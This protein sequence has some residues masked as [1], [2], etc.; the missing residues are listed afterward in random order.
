MTIA[1]T[2][3]RIAVILAI[4]SYPLVFA[5]L[6]Y[7]TDPP[8]SDP[9]ISN[10]NANINLIESGDVLIYGEHNIPYA[11]LPAEDADDT[12]IFRLIDTDNSTH[13]GA[14]LPFTQLDNGY[15]EGGFSFYFTASDNLT[16]D[17]QYIIR[18]SQNPANFDSPQHY[19]YV[20]P[21]SA[22][23]SSV[24]Q[25]DNQVELTLNIISMA[26]NLESAHDATLLESSAGGTVLSDPTGERYF[27]GIIYGIQLMAPDLFL[28]Q[29]LTIDTADRLWTTDQF[30]QYEGRFTGTW[31]GTTTANTSATFGTTTPTL[32]TMVFLLPIILGAIV[33]SAIKFRKVDP[34][35]MVAALAL[36]ATVLMGW[37]STAVFATIYQLFAI[38]VGYLW[39]YAR[40]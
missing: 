35:F 17:Q 23:T 28:V 25:D 6:V 13:L 9:T 21:L 22:W 3:I 39:F 31:L 1:K 8:D 32:M 36:I 40:S 4:V 15:N 16:T 38:Y 11:A 18:I 10:V 29:V 34:A 7:A 26:Q 27:R 14:I 37:M 19:D 30:D 20:M 2:I 33:I 12:Y 5:S 24:T